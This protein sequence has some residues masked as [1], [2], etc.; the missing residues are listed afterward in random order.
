MRGRHTQRIRSLKKAIVKLEDLNRGVLFRYSRLD[1][2]SCYLLAL[3]FWLAPCTGFAQRTQEVR[4]LEGYVT[5]PAG[6]PVAHAVLFVEKNDTIF[7]FTQSDSSGYYRL[8][9][10]IPVP[11]NSLLVVKHL[12]YIETRYPFKEAIRQETGRFDVVLHERVEKL[13]EVIIRPNFTRLP[14][15][16]TTTILLQTDS[17]EKQSLE[18]VLKQLPGF[19]VDDFGN[20]T[21]K[22]KP[23]E[24]VF[25]EGVDLTDANYKR[26]TRN[27]LAEYVAKID[28]IEHFVEN[29]LLGGIVYSDAV[30]LNLNID[31]ARKGKPF[32]NVDV[33]AG[34]KYY[35]DLGG[36]VFSVN[37]VHKFSVQAHTNNV[38][39][40]QDPD[41][42]AL[43]R[44]TYGSSFSS[45]LGSTPALEYTLA[46]PGNI[47]NTNINNEHHFGL[48]GA[49]ESKKRNFLWNYDI[50]FL[51]DKLL[52]KQTD[53]LWVNPDR[54]TSSWFNWVAANYSRNLI[55]NVYARN[56]AKWK[57][58]PNNQLDLSMYFNRSRSNTANLFNQVIKSGDV[59]ESDSLQKNSCSSFQQMHVAA[60]YTRKLQHNRAFVINVAAG[61]NTYPQQLSLRSNL[62]RFTF[63]WALQDTFEVIN[64]NLVN[65]NREVLARIKYVSSVNRL[66]YEIFNEISYSYAQFRP[67]IYNENFTDTN[68]LQV[69]RL[70]Y[71][72]GGSTTFG[73]KSILVEG[74]LAGRLLSFKQYGSY[75]F[76]YI[77]T[78]LSVPVYKKIKWKSQF[79]YDRYFPGVQ[80]ITNFYYLTDFNWLHAGLGNI[81]YKE[82]IILTTSFNYENLR[83]FWLADLT[84]GVRFSSPDFV[85]HF[86][87]SPLMS[88]EQL[89]AAY[90]SKL[91]FLQFKAEKFIPYLNIRLTSTIDGNR[92]A[93]YNYINATGLRNNTIT[94]CNIRLESGSSF[95]IPFNF[96][97]T[98]KLSRTKAETYFENTP[99]ALVNSNSISQVR[100]ALQYKRKSLTGRIIYQRFWLANLMFNQVDGSLFIKPS[101]KPFTFSLQF[102]NITNQKFL[103]QFS[104]TDLYYSRT[105]YSLLPAV[106]LLGINW[107]F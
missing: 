42:A 57:I 96:F 32:G 94:L 19:S 26:I 30:A 86:E 68:N 51:S 13:D 40:R 55:R 17:I 60:E 45:T 62:N 38:G 24:K 93:F 22:G 84:A 67:A 105:G 8:K 102:Q 82:N 69:N 79:L 104:Q 65:E 29:Q 59:N 61:E 47:G 16:D 2:C 107:S 70:F 43:I 28:V 58:N 27:L 3:L 95:S 46:L 90:S 36:N 89:V 9:V 52:V 5:G 54:D 25:V 21:Y 53:S 64:Q 73:W 83:N 80:E 39:K 97:V 34:N 6:V 106:I 85:P 33:H 37:N 78:T 98:V 71:E 49:L 103:Y 77:Q 23:I 10:D 15:N 14:Y 56:R 35:R 4:T 92:L 81:Q 20:I 99:S 11:E 101:G 41:A 66:S 100:F 44:E 12:G 87:I 1:P 76:P 7:L 50:S 31:A 88:T 91:A 18:E 75:V 72:L 74:I 63:P 48:A